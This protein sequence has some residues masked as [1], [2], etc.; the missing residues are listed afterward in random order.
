MTATS[1]L[2]A[3]S[4]GTNLYAS[5]RRVIAGTT[6]GNAPSFSTSRYSVF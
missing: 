3:P 2:S 4:A 1:T 6:I 5:R